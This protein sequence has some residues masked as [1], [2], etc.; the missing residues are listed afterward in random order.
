M[1]ILILIKKNIFSFPG[2]LKE[3]DIFTMFQL[4]A[5]KNPTNTIATKIVMNGGYVY[6]PTIADQDYRSSISA[7][8]DPGFAADIKNG[9]CYKALSTKKNLDD[10]DDYCRNYYDAELLL[11]DT[12]SQVK[13]FME[14]INTGNLNN[15]NTELLSITAT[16]RCL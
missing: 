13:D 8:C 7:Q 4:L 1:W 2:L 14:L 9:F 10:G 6:C 5:S 16:W 3:D 15:N 12:N 11:F